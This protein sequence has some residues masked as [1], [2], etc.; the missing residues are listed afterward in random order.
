MSSDAS[1][2][3]RDPVTGRR[4]GFRFG[5]VVIN[6]RGCVRGPRGAVLW[7]AAFWA[8]AFWAAALWVSAP[9]C[10]IFVK[11]WQFDPLD[12]SHVR[13]DMNKLGA[14]SDPDRPGVRVSPLFKDDHEE[15]RLEHWA[16]GAE[17]GFTARG[18]AELL[19][20]AG[21]ANESSDELTLHS[22]VRVPD[23]GDVALKAG[24]EGARIWVK[25]GH[26][27]EIIVPGGK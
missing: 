24:A 4:A 21:M 12:R 1:A 22:W 6:A 8:A 10:V 17:G 20:L 2:I 14:V 3:R 7:A 18:G 25:T 5:C 16:P 11:L 13:I 19:V 15:V 23:G 27:R 9:G 26:L